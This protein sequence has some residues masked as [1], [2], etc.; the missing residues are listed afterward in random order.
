MRIAVLDIY[1][2]Q[3]NIN[4]ELVYYFV[5]ADNFNFS[6]S[7]TTIDVTSIHTLLLFFKYN[8]L[9]Y[10]DFKDSVTTHV[11]PIWG[12]LTFDEKKDFAEFL[13]VPGGDSLD[14]YFTVDEQWELHQSILTRPDI[15]T[16]DIKNLTGRSILELPNTSTAKIITTYNLIDAE[17]ASG[18]SGT[19]GY[20]GVSGYSLSLIHICAADDR[21]F[22]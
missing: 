3:S 4:D 1:G 14:N 13:I 2:F 11:F 8:R 10:F 19:S 22:V 16:F 7:P 20:S 9:E 18:Y 12:S 21:A 5:V 17:A 6:A 15:F